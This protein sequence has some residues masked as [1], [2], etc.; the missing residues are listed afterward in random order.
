MKKINSLTTSLSGVSVSLLILFLSATFGFADKGKRILNIPEGS[1]GLIGYG[2]LI[3]LQSMEQTLGHKYKG[4][5]HQVHLM[6]Y[7]RAWTCLRP[8][9][10][11]QANSAGTE[12]IKGSFLRNNERVPFIGTV[13]LNVHPKKKA[14]INCILYQITTEELA[15][16]DK[17]EWGYRRVDV[18]DKIDEFRFRGG[19]VYVYEGLPG[20][21]DRSSYDKGTYI[22]IKEYIDMVASACDGTGKDFRSEFDKTTRPCA[23][24]IVPLEKITWERAK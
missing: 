21:L 13:N 19:E 22:A 20:N 3:S 7:E 16:F 15:R 10:D 9:N 23:Y 24:Q 11:Y 1:A 17:R 5:L 4:P 8:N 6:G 12:K 18:T 2:S 14:M